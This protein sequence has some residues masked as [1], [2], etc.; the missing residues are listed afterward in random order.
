MSATVSTPGFRL[1]VTSEGA[2]KLASSAWFIVAVIGQVIFASSTALFYGLTALR[3][4]EQA[5]NKHL[6][7]GYIPGDPVGNA[8][9]AAHLV[10]AVVIILTGAT[11]FLPQIR[12]RAPALH[13]WTG[14][15]FIFTAFSVSLAGLYMLIVRGTATSVTQQIGT[16]IL[17]V[18]IIGC[19]TMALVTAMRRDIARH[20]RWAF[21]L[22]LLVSAALF[23]RAAFLLWM[24]AVVTP[25]TFDPTVIQ[26]SSL[27]F[28]TFAQ[29]I[30]PLTVLEAYFWVQRHGG[31]AA[32]LAMAGGLFAITLAMG[33]GIAA[34]SAG[35]FLP[36]VKAAF[37][38]RHS[39][40]EAL[41]ATIKSKGIDAALAQYAALKA[42]QNASY[43]FDE[44][45][46]NGLGYTLLRTKDAPDAIRIFQLNTQ[47]FP[48]SGNT[49][50]SLGEA[51]M[52]NG[53]TPEAIANY[54][55]SLA[56]NPA[57]HNAVIMLAK[58]G[59]H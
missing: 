8:A 51:Y 40:A 42:T 52:N 14:R 24:M 11:Q 45:E 16:G 19:A 37:D 18:L 21:R 28:L 48:K 49:W 43:N 41:A 56:L 36:N 34:A 47:I 44:D 5:W 23:I 6:A 4:D 53:N 26:G 32:R 15:V 50:D 58:M 27:T 9:L 35:I 39:I 13:R 57:N 59:A 22:F 3:G 1:N 2:L 55:K 38:P 30:V 25:G 33:A 29:Y 10:S 31:R 46:L 54:H 7:H 20:R 12:R 17:A